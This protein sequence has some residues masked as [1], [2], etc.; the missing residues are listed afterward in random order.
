MA[1]VSLNAVVAAVAGQI[2]CDMQGESAVIEIESSTYYG[3]GGVGTL[4]DR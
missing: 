4:I 2:W 3:F 1:R